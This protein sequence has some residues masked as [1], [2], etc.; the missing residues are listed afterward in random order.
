MRNQ[1]LIGSNPL[2]SGFIPECE[3]S[4]LNWTF[5]TCQPVW[6]SSLLVGLEELLLYFHEQANEEERELTNCEVCVI[7]QNFSLLVLW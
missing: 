2:T 6:S 3:V 5:Q 4:V 7:Y 1:L